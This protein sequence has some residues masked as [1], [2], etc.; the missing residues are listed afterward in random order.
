MPILK[1]EI[2]GSKIEINYQENE[3]E[4]LIHLIDRFKLRINEFEN[5][6]GKF[7][8]N[9]IILLAALK[10]EDAAFD[11]NKKLESSI[12]NTEISKNR[13]NQINDKIREVVILKDQISDLSEN[14]N[15]L[16]EQNIKTM[17]EINKI[18]KK[19]ISL[20]NKILIKNE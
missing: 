7:S 17:E 20:I 8:D 5:L 14:N 18:N 16:K 6:K 19:L 11:L 10:S 9:K 3:K 12:L 1:T 2:L 13:K 4:K 15:I